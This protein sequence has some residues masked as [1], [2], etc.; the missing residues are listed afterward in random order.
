MYLH[1][2]RK[3]LRRDRKMEGRVFLLY[4]E[5]QVHAGT[6]FEIGVVDLPIQ[7]ERTTKFPIIHGIK[8]ALRAYF[9]SLI[10]EDK[11]DEK[12]IEEI[13]GSEPKSDKGTVPGSLSFSEARILLFPVRNP[14]R[15]FVWVTCPL[16]LIKFAKSVGDN[17]VVKELEEANIDYGKAVSFYGSGEVFLEEVKLE[18]FVGELPR[19]RELISKISNCAPVDYLKKKME[20]DVVVVNDVLFSE[21]VQ[22]MTEVVPRVRI[23]REKKTVEEGGLWYEEYLPQDTV[24]YFVVRKTYY[25]NKEDSGKDSLMEVFENEVNGELINIGGKETVGKGMMWVHAWR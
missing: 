5:T 1:E 23:N 25:G 21:I 13:F 22:A 14:D 24:M 16:V 20:S 17:D 3:T 2:V 6:G 18:P 7:R 9:R 19:T 11:I 4:A 10:K 15:L 12:K 8:G